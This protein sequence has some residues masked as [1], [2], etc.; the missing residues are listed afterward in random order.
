MNAAQPVLGSKAAKE[1]Q[2][3]VKTDE[4][5]QKILEDFRSNPPQMMCV[6]IL[7]KIPQ[8]Y[9]DSQLQ[10]YKK[11]IVGD[12]E[13]RFALYFEKFIFR[14]LA[15]CIKIAGNA[16]KLKL[17]G[18]IEGLFKRD[19]WASNLERYYELEPSILTQ[20][21]GRSWRYSFGVINS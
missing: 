11:E 2:D 6:G 5:T 15:N 16:E 13:S 4:A 8:A 10:E 3:S 18:D 20:A 9:F 7:A 14:G 1:A 17:L 21:I 12:D 19:S